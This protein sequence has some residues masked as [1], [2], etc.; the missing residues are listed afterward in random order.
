MSAPEA[1]KRPCGSSRLFRLQQ[2]PPS[3]GQDP[4]PAK[5]R[6]RPGTVQSR[7]Q[8]GARLHF[9]F[10]LLHCPSRLPAL[11]SCGCVRHRRHPPRSLRGAA[12]LLPTRSPAR[13]E[14]LQHKEGRGGIAVPLPKLRFYSFPAYRRLSHWHWPP[15][16]CT[17]EIPGARLP[18]AGVFAGISPQKAAASS[19]G[20]AT[21]PGSRSCLSAA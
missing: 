8:A 11:V 10:A 12:Y 21:R 17:A 1:A 5:T 14:Q 4:L 3:D 13:G 9:V 7:M 19:L 6:L 15:S 2:A 16:G 18:E 20:K